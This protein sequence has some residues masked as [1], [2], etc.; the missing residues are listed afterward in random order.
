MSAPIKL[1]CLL[2]SPTLTSGF[3]RVGQNLLK[4]WAAAGVEIDV[5]GIAF[6]G[7][8]Y[9]QHPYIKRIMPAGT[10]RQFDHWA[11]AQQLSL[12]L[13]QLQTGGY[14]HVWIMQDTFQLVNFHFP[15]ALR[16]LCT[17]KNIRSTYYFPV[18]APLDPEWTD[19][20]AAVDCPIAY[21]EYGRTSARAALSMRKLQ[22]AQHNATA[23]DKDK[24]DVTGLNFDVPVEVLPHGVDTAVYQPMAD[25]LE[26][27]AKF[28]SQDFAGPEDFL[29]VNVNVNQRRKDV[30]R[31]LE[32]LKAVRELGVP[33]KLVMHMSNV[34]DDGLNLELV[35]RQLGLRLNVDWCHHGQLFNAGQ[36]SFS[37]AQ[38]VEL[39]NIADL[40]LTTTLGEGWGLGITEALA[41]GTAVG[42][43]M[44]T[45]CR[46]IAQTAVAAGL[47]SQFVEFP[48]EDHVLVQG[49]DNS[50]CRPRTDVA[51]AAQNLKHYYDSGLWRN[52]GGLTQPVREWLSWDRIAREML[53]LVK[54]EA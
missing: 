25:R 51:G 38:M 41:C 18:D 24:V 23:A 46:E 12:F 36:G 49:L 34:S 8:G 31:S 17:E 5:W 47:G 40:Y 4:R 3:A 42:L 14:T 29:M 44:N 30:A 27:R 10:G 32:V 20:I 11:S 6:L 43:P 52:R 28:W 45:S 39:Y 26:R 50:R 37:E 21:T 7:W 54:G 9:E 1:L 22:V 48:V 19:I 16:R 15:V 53:R 13:A 35:A 33:A 2:D